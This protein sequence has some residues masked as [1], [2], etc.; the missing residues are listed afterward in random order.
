MISLAAPAPREVPRE[1]AVG[2]P[3]SHGT[4]AGPQASKKAGAEQ[5]ARERESVP[6]L[7]SRRC[8]PADTAARVQLVRTVAR[9]RL[10]IFVVLKQLRQCAVVDL[11]GK[12]LLV[13]RAHDRLQA[14][15]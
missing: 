3:A 10:L 13:Q 5:T 2:Q 7:R 4:H 1:A 9:G 14:G 15:R 8:C 6:L 12:A 11:G